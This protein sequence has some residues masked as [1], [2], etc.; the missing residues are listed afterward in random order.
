MVKIRPGNYVVGSAPPDDYHVATRQIQLPG[1]WIDKLAVT[2][3]Q[4]KA[5]VDSTGRPAP[6]GWRS[7]AFPAGYANHPVTGLTWN[8]A[9]AFCAG[10]NKR[11]PGEAEWEVA[12]RGP[13]VEPPIYPWGNDPTA[14]GQTSNLPQRDTYEVG[15]AAFN[16]SPFDVYDMVGAVWQWVD[17]PYAPVPEGLHILRG[18]R[19]GLLADLAYRQPAKADDERFT[20]VAGVRCAADQ[21]TGE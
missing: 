10:V 2:N 18:G 13:A 4:Y 9:T 12:G 16:R 7:G 11:L 1:F 3:A 19:Y 8:D 21:V 15:T 5:F 17:Q 20:R 14:G 6:A